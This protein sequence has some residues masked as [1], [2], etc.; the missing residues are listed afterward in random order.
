MIQ[1]IGDCAW[2][3]PTWQA[4]PQDRGGAKI[5]SGPGWPANHAMHSYRHRWC[6][7]SIGVAG[8]LLNI[9]T[10]C[11]DFLSGPNCRKFQSRGT[12]PAIPNYFWR[13]V[14]T[15]ANSLTDARGPLHSDQANRMVTTGSLRLMLALRY[16]IV[17]TFPAIPCVTLP[18]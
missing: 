18:V 3:A 12:A 7:N 1:T 13:Q 6:V 11:K 16:G 5:G 15:K 2:N 8:V 4:V 10:D 9:L 14:L 17:A